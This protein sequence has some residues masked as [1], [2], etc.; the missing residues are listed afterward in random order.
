[1]MPFSI[2]VIFEDEVADS[3]NNIYN[4][5]LSIHITSAATKLAAQRAIHDGSTDTL[6]SFR[7]V[8]SHEVEDGESVC[9][10]GD[11]IVDWGESDTE[12]WF[13]NW[14]AFN[15]SGNVRFASKHKLAMELAKNPPKRDA[16]PNR[17]GVHKNALSPKSPSISTTS[18]RP[19]NG[20]RK[21]RSNKRKRRRTSSITRFLGGSPW[22]LNLWIHL[23]ETKLYILRSV[24]EEATI[25]DLSNC[26]HLQRTDPRNNKKVKPV[27]LHFDDEVLMIEFSD[28]ETTDYLFESLETNWRLLHNHVRTPSIPL[29]YNWLSV[30]TPEECFTKCQTGDILLYKTKALQG[31]VT[32]AITMK[33]WDHVAMFVWMQVDGQDTLGVLEALSDKGTQLW[34]WD[35]YIREKY[36]SEYSEIVVRHLEIPDDTLKT[37][38]QW[39]L[40]NFVQNAINTPYSIIRGLFR[41]GSD[42]LND[43]SRTFFCS[44]LV[45]KAYKTVG[46]LQSNIASRRYYPGHFLQ[47]DGIAILCGSSLSQPV[48]IDFSKSRQPAAEPQV[49]TSDEEVTSS[50]K[51]QSC[52]GCIIC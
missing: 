20:S 33:D 47:S 51:I 31:T 43:P 44:S 22:E 7:G 40:Q 6:S 12:E 29:P 16:S 23:Y 39:Q 37:R 30:Y 26:E 17:E 2:D 4:D 35:A 32:R 50:R 8:S 11:Y 24:I 9:E 10:G 25:F 46:L 14:Q 27:V 28:Q 15:E 5:P 41:R 13:S 49:I 3:N 52:R 42:D 45:A 36:D 21:R 1:L 34:P 38:V 48:K 18:Q 19:S